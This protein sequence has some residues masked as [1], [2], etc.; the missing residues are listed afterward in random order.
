MKDQFLQASKELAR[1]ID[2]IK[3]LRI[4]MNS[5]LRGGIPQVRST[6]GRFDT[7][8]YGEDSYG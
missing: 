1:I 4:W 3:I 6:G 8:A 5:L 2:A 7:R